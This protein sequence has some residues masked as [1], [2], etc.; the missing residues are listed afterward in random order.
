MTSFTTNMRDL[1]Q[2]L[3][4]AAL[5]AG[6]DPEIDMWHRVRVD[7]G[8]VNASVW[9]TNGYAAGLSIASVIDNGDGELE[10]FD[11]APAQIKDVL[12]L[13][14]VDAKHAEEQLLQVELTGEEHVTFRDVSGLFPGKT[15]EL[16]RLPALDG[17]G[18]PVA[19][20][21]ALLGRT[22]HAG[23]RHHLDGVIVTNPEWVAL[24]ASAARV[25]N[26]ALTLT[27]Y[28][29]GTGRGRL[30][31]TA[32]ESFIGV[33]MGHTDQGTE[34]VREEVEH[35]DAWRRRLPAVTTHD[36]VVDIHAALAAADD[37]PDE[38]EEGSD[39]D[40]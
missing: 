5:F 35:R 1:R 22:V 32:G 24:F 29:E 14:P 31:A 40:D 26:E 4:S 38:P 39:D 30:L 12:N 9:A 3:K 6:K 25:Y 27:P 36:P 23:D 20:I 17:D 18:D 37:E 15:V 34:H 33:L 8:P 7:V 16:P 2:A 10:T 21:P 28:S 19:K 13:F 11:L